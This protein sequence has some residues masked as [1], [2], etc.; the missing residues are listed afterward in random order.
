[1]LSQRDC[2]PVGS[3]EFRFIEKASSDGMDN[4]KRIDSG[5]IMNNIFTCSRICQ[6]SEFALASVVGGVLGLAGLGHLANPLLF[7]GSIAQY[8]IVAPSIAVFISALLPWI[9]LTTATMLIVRVERD[10]AFA[11]ATFLSIA[12]TIAQVSAILRSLKIDCGCFGALSKREVGAESLTIAIT[13]FL[14]SLAGFLLTARLP[15]RIGSETASV[16]TAK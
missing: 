4:K 6:F 3:K 13:F 15:K 8:D 7:L 16:E 14:C 11:I 10:S 12:F 5:S 1:M 9:E 2:L